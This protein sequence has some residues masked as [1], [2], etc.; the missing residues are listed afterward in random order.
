MPIIRWKSQA[1]DSEKVDRYNIK[2]LQKFIKFMKVPFD[3]KTK[4]SWKKGPRNLKSKYYKYCKLLLISP[5][6][7]ASPA[8]HPSTCKQ[9][10]LINPRPN[11]LKLIDLL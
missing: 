1:F 3:P 5:N 2:D 7:E 6:S 4:K 8:T 10:Y 11:V 9:K